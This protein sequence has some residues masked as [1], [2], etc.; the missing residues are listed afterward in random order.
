MELE[1]RSSNS[2]WKKGK[3]SQRESQR[4]THNLRDQGMRKVRNGASEGKRKR[5]KEI[6]RETET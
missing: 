5:P 2:V 1:T 6:K 3:G 4:H